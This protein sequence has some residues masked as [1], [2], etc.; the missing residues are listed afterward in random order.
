MA[1]SAWF[2]SCPCIA[3]HD[4][5]FSVLFWTSY[6][7]FC[8]QARYL[9]TPS[10][11][12]STRDARF[13][14]KHQFLHQKWTALIPLAWLLGLC[15]CW[16]ARY[17]VSPRLVSSTRDAQQI[18]KHQFLHLK[19]TTF[20]S[21]ERPPHSPKITF[22][23]FLQGFVPCSWCP[24]PSNKYCNHS[25]QNEYCNPRPGLYSLCR[26][27]LKAIGVRGKGGNGEKGKGNGGGGRENGK[28]GKGE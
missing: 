23:C 18:L 8:W 5:S 4:G 20:L 25:P 14:H 1:T 26:A 22:V 16:Q 24:V 11:V 28:G 9:V 21:S 7:F 17:L 13:F 10:L 19:N 6:L 15:F 2:S 12:S 3:T 27:R